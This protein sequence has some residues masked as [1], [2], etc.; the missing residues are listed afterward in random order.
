MTFN[1]A[2]L[3]ATLVIAVLLVGLLV[4]GCIYR[5]KLFR[6]A[7]PARRERGGEENP[8]RHR[9][10]REPSESHHTN[11]R[12]VEQGLWLAVTLLE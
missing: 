7:D 8:G 4:T 2:G 6:D 12:N 10:L 11:L 9:G 3:L 1:Q 5:Q